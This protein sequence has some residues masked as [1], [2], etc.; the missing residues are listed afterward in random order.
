LAKWLGKP[1]IAAGLARRGIVTVLI[2]GGPW[3]IRP[4]I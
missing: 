3:Q 1:E 2:R 4:T